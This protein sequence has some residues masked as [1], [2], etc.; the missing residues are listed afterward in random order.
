MAE[1]IIVCGHGPGISDAVARRFGKAGHPVAIVARSTDRLAKAAS[2]LAD[3]GVKAQAFTCDLGKPE[4]V[5]KMI[6]EARAALGPIGVLHWNAYAG[7]AGDLT[8]AA[9][10]ELSTVFGVSVQGLVAAVQASLPDLEAKQ[11]AVLVTGGGLCFYE[12]SVDGMALGFGASGLAI[13]KAAQHKTVGI[14]AQGLKAKG[15]YVGE[16]VVTG[17]VKG[18]AFDHGNATLEASAIAEKFWDLY[19]KRDPFTV[20]F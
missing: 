16:V 5:K 8:Q 15:V 20:T 17:L 4:A 18:T 13:G 14:L 9:P 6:A 11:G 19:Q 3:A 7:G 2:A 12:P 1:T 10:E